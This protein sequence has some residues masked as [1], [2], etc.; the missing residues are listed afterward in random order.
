MCSIVTL[1][2]F[3]SPRTET[4]EAAISGGNLRQQSPTRSFSDSQINKTPHPNRP[5]REANDYNSF[6]K[7]LFTTMTNYNLFYDIKVKMWSAQVSCMWWK[8]LLEKLEKNSGLD[9]FQKMTYSCN[10]VDSQSF[11]WNWAKSSSETSYFLI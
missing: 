7:L 11:I 6:L 3:L 10:Y 9:A 5:H 8:K 2:P 1:C 4:E